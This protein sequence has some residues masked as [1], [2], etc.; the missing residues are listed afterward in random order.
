MKTKQF[1]LKARVKRLGCMVNEEKAKEGFCMVAA[2]SFL[3]E[4]SVSISLIKDGVEVHWV[5]VN[6]YREAKVWVK[7]FLRGY[8]DE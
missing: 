4:S 7:G 2:L 6:S 5:Y 8:L 3:N 1:H